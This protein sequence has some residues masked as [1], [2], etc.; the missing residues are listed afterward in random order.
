MCGPR[1][2]GRASVENL[3]ENGSK[4]DIFSKLDGFGS[5]KEP[6]VIGSVAAS[7]WCGRF[8]S[9]LA[10]PARARVF[11]SEESSPVRR[12]FYSWYQRDGYSMWSQGLITDA[13]P[14]L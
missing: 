12:S 1:W 14:A 9:A 11:A 10:Q 3:V 6:N 4:I 8:R 5:N 2:E 13:L 7:A